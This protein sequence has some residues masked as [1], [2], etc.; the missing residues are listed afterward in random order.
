VRTTV[1]GLDGKTDDEVQAAM[2]DKFP[3][4]IASGVISR[5]GTARCAPRPDLP[6]ATSGDGEIS[7]LVTIASSLVMISF[8]D[9]VSAGEM[10]SKQ[11]SHFGQRQR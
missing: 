8:I 9:L 2:G 5:R 7:S 11:Q 1:N 10:T 4:H 3:K 6:Y